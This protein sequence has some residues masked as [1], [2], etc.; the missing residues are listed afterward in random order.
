[1]ATTV[2][3]I[4]VAALAR[5][6]KNRPGY[7]A[8]NSTEL[9][10]SVYRVLRGFF[11]AGAR[12]NPTFYGKTASVALTAGG[13]PRPADCEAVFRI[14]TPATPPVEVVVV[15]YDDRA[16]ETSKP[17]LYRLGQ[18]Y[19]SAGN[20][21]DPTVG[22]LTF[23]YSKQ[24]G[25]LAGLTD[26]LDPLWPETFNNALIIDLAMYLAI[27]DGRADEAQ[28]LQPER[29]RWVTLYQAFLE[30]ETMNEVR[31]FANVRLF[32]SPS[33]HDLTKML[34]GTPS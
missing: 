11:A 25:V 13:W 21:L 15:P 30:H 7:L 33:M 27:K 18:V 16:A 34:A 4:V 17:A 28:V 6:A 19:F 20:S 26:T 14:E 23:W 9:T 5:S 3:D 22:N 24:P 10:G 12:I 31:R 1:M 2:Q 29:D 32:N 8:T